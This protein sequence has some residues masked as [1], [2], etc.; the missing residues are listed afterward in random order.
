MSRKFVPIAT[1][2]KQA[3]IFFLVL[4][5]V[6]LAACTQ[7]DVP[8]AAKHSNAI[9]QVGP[10]NPNATNKLPET[11]ARGVER[12]GSRETFIDEVSAL[13]KPDKL[14]AI[15]SSN[16]Q[17]PQIAL[18]VTYSPSSMAN[19][20]ETE[21][22]CSLSIA[23]NVAGRANISERTK[24]LLNCSQMG[25]A[26]TVRAGLSIEVGERKISMTQQETRSNA[27]YGFEKDTDGSWFVRNASMNYPETNSDTG[28]LQV[29]HLQVVYPVQIR[30]VRVSDYD[31]D[32][33]ASRFVKTFV[34]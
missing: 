17:V 20:E 2:R 4:I 8:P 26:E 12:G 34:R 14:V 21:P 15:K 30:K 13:A 23:E 9:E 1:M 16:G 22:V 29:V 7:Q 33:V 19:G 31:Y 6:T 32:S 24:K 25:S 27:T 11:A 10:Q 28:E 18:L 5:S 3:L